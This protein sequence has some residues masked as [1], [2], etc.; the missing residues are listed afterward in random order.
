LEKKAKAEEKKGCEDSSLLM[1][2]KGEK[3]L[4]NESKFQ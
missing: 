3:S 1:N 2:W 4:K